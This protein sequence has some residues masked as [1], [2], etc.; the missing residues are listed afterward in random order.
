M[1][2]DGV[3]RGFIVNDIGWGAKREREGE[4]GGLEGEWEGEGME[5]GRERQ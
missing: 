3:L 5:G 2:N 1:R 4:T